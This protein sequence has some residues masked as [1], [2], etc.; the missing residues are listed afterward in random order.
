MPTPKSHDQGATTAR[1]SR[2][3]LGVLANAGR[4]FGLVWQE[5][6]GLA[7][8]LASLSVL[9]GAL[10]AGIAYLA[11]L[12]VDAV[13]VAVHAP[14]EEHKRDVLVLL[15]FELCCVVL[16]LALQR[17]LSVCDALLRVRLSQS[18]VERVLQRA[19]TLELQA[20]EDAALQD[21]LR[22]IV[23]QAPERP[24]SL[25]RRA[26]VALQQTVT[27][28]GL[29]LL[30]AG[31]SAWL[32]ALLAAATLPALWVELRLNADAFRLFR[33]HSSESRRQRYLETLLTRETHAKE[34]KMYGVGPALLRRHRDIF[35]R[36]YPQDRALTVRRAVWGFAL[37]L[38]SALALSACYLWVTWSAVERQA[39]IGALAMLF[40][41]LR[42][43]QSSSSD[44]VS[45][46]AGMH[47]DQLYLAAL[48]GFLA[49][50][51]SESVGTATRG[52][53]PGAG[54]LL[55]DVSFTYPGSANP[56]VANINL[57]LPPGRRV[58]VL[59]KNGAGKTT[60]LKLLTGLYRPS[61]GRITLDGLPLEQWLPANLSARFAVAF[62]D[63]GRYQLLAG[64]NVGIGSTET[65]DNRARWRE[66]AHAALVGELLEGL[67]AGYETQLGQWFEGGREL[68]M[69][70]WQ[71]V[72]L[73]R[74]H[75]R[76]QAD[77]VIL[78]EP[79]ASIDT[80]AEAALLDELTERTR[81]RTA[82]LVSHRA[83]WN[84]PEALV[85]ELEAGRLVGS[86][87][88]PAECVLSHSIDARYPNA[89]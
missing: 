20:L 57:Y 63:F 53:K 21:E 55:E 45:V 15:A 68:S 19:L 27:L 86:M 6:R 88:E 78:D 25:V 23:D 54:L 17:A 79:T 8:C 84:D 38:V 40:V 66:A 51:P 42:Q 33:A 85:V 73:A 10:P 22:L 11:K 43:A 80:A 41:V 24:L 3:A 46:L 65:L 77:I 39:S 60:L 70:E 13:A 87:G 30:L 74:I 7:L 81:G 35:D 69:G 61:S 50:A 83:A 56:A 64:E 67:P 12:I 34:L 82:I 47:E 1:A 31:F 16:L 76:P 18:I 52:S 9:T 32:L 59:G 72:A 49:A 26:L 44:L 37:G 5:N 48:D 14:S 4:A 28:G 29:L 36:W 75:A 58:S 89:R 2:R 71:R 62:Q